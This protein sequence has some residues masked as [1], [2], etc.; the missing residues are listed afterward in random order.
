MTP[1]EEGS[2]AAVAGKSYKDN[3][4]EL[5]T[6]ECEDWFKGMIDAYSQMPIPEPVIEKRYWDDFDEPFKSVTAAIH[7]STETAGWKD[8]T[9]SVLEYQ[10][11]MR[12][13][14]P[15]NLRRKDR[16]P[17]QLPQDRVVKLGS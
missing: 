13:D 9:E 12:P 6:K 16:R 7:M 1:Y 4:Y 3:P 14:D 17:P 15:Y 8:F 11:E 5:L 2:A 10:R